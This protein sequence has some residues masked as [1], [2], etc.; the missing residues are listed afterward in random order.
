MMM[1]N[2]RT[3]GWGEGE[4]TSQAPGT[5]QF[6]WHCPESVRGEREGIA[7]SE[8][9]TRLPFPH[10]SIPDFGDCPLSVSGSR[11]PPSSVPPP[12]G[13]APVTSMATLGDDICPGPGAQLLISLPLLTCLPRG[14]I[15]VPKYKLWRLK[16]H[17]LFGQ[18]FPFS[19]RW[20][21]QNV[22]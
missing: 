16:I 21:Y 6:T 18:G 4:G 10:W 2:F 8:C 19:P 17:V 12:A 7:P 13:C 22:Y 14:T 11:S 5:H 3:P 15:P 1:S 9:T 20:H